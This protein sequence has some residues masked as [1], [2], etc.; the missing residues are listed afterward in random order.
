VRAYHASRGGLLLLLLLLPPSCFH[1]HQFQ[2]PARR[3]IG[4]GSGCPV[5][6]RGLLL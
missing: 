4:D 3:V 2:L 1:F 6:S 5:L